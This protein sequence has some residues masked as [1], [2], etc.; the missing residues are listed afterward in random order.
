LKNSSVIPQFLSSLPAKAGSK[1]SHTVMA[2]HEEYQGRLS[3]DTFVRVVVNDRMLS[4]GLTWS[5]NARQPN[6]RRRAGSGVEG[7]ATE[8][9]A[10]SAWKLASGIPSMPVRFPAFCRP[11]EPE[12]RRRRNSVHSMVCTS[13]FRKTG[14]FL[15]AKKALHFLRWSAVPMV[16]M[17]AEIMRHIKNGNIMASHL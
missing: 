8:K 2:K 3:D 5:N 17:G 1:N 7:K 12:A 11:G 16:A 15:P 4:V 9:C 6:F 13:D 14:V 10:G